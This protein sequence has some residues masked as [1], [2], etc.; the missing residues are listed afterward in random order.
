MGLLR[1][2]WLPL[3]IVAVVVIAGFTVNRVRGFFGS[4]PVMIA[5]DTIATESTS[6]EPKTITYE[7]FGPPGAVADINYL[8]LD[9]EAQGVSDA[10]LPWEVTLST[11]APSAIANVVAQ[12]NRTSIGCRIII[13]GQV[14]DEKISNGVNSQT[15]CLVKSA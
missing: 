15:F 13:D 2:V 3:V 5:P 1:R 11:T 8:D 4:E 9:I 14:R 6:F 10:T 7:V 12:G